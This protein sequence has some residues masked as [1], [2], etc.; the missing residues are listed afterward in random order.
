M[1]INIKAGGMVYSVEFSI[2]PGSSETHLTAIAKSSKDLDELQTAIINRGGN[3]ETIG[4][5]I[6][7]AVE[8]KLK[9]PIDVDYSYKGAGYGLKL[10]FYS[11][12]KKL[13]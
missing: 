2:S 12:A 10:D 13:K 11:I 4:G 5:I 1:K 3:D 6:A 7:K 8:N 9:L